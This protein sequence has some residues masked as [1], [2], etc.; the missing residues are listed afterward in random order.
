MD[1]FPYDSPR[2]FQREIYWRA[3]SALEKGV[4]ALINAPTGLGKTAAVLG[5]ALKYAFERGLGVHYVVRTRNELEPP[6]RELSRLRERGVDVEYVV[7]KSRQDMCCYRQLKKLE[8]LEF[9]AECSLLKK[10][11]R[12]EYYPPKDVEVPLKN[13]S[14]YVKTL[15]ASR[16]CP[17]EYAKERAGR[18]RVVV[19][20]YYYVFGREAA[21][22]RD[23]VVVVDEA[24]S[25]FDAVASLHTIKISE[26]DLRHAYRECRRHGFLEEASKIYK[27]LTLVR[28]TSG[29]VEDLLGQVGDLSLEEAVLDITRKKAEAGL[30]P[31]TPLLLVKEL[32]EALRSRV[33]YLA[34][35]REVDSAKYLLLTP[36]DPVSIVK[37]ALEQAANVIYISGTLPIQLFSEVLNITKYEALDVAFYQYVPR[38]N[39]LSVV[40]VG[41]TTRYQER[42]EEMYLKIAGRIAAV[43]NAS[44]GGVLAVFPSYEV[45]KAVRKYLK[46]SI[47]HWFEGFDEFEIEDLPNKFFIGAVAGGRFVEGVEYVVEGVNLLSTVV[48]VGVPYPEPSAYLERRVELLKPRLRERAWDAVY[49]YQAVVN[50]R[51]AI[52]RLFR[53]PN[54]KGVLVFLDRRY[55]EPDLWNALKDVLAGAMIVENVEEAVHHL[56]LF[57]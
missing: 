20:T 36:L 19:S 46:I 31:Y 5:A 57:R 40:D 12:C 21:D 47:P 9:L 11:G 23:K 35:V 38:D 27:L 26:S 7:I 13:V 30:T 33:K 18:A 16:T 55:V 17:Y 41:V 6:V 42:T 10:T 14:T 39:F 51:Q 2:P 49:L 43:I 3:Y 56:S 8:Y 4:P 1:Y 34:E 54:D 44:V 15:C 48:I 28:K 24:H 22:V 32:V 53:G 37:K 50:I 52:G 25:L 29:V 45:L